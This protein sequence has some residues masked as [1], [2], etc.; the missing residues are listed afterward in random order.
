MRIFYTI[1]KGLLKPILGLIYYL[2]GIHHPL[3]MLI[4][5]TYG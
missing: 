3:E 4:N 1:T 2:G 5:H